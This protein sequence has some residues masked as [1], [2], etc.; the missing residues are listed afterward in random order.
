MAGKEFTVTI[1]LH[2]GEAEHS[3]FTSDLSREYVEFNRSEYA[4]R[5]KGGKKER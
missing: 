1:D 3:V 2:L 4:V 5:V